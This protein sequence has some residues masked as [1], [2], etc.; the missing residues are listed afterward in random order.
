MEP[1]GI[2]KGAIEIILPKWDPVCTGMIAKEDRVIGKK[3]GLRVLGNAKLGLMDC[4]SRGGGIDC[5][6]LMNRS[7]TLWN[8]LDGLRLNLNPG[9]EY[10]W[11]ERLDVLER[12]YVLAVEDFVREY[13]GDDVHK[14]E[15]KNLEIGMYFDDILIMRPGKQ[16]RINGLD[17]EENSLEGDLMMRN[18]HF[19]RDKK[20]K[21]R[22]TEGRRVLGGGIDG[23]PIP[24]E[25][26]DQ[27][28]I[29][30]LPKRL[31]SVK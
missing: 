11:N 30:E 19:D 29:Y 26:V 16:S 2:D 18:V 15:R 9:P 17:V 23:C 24:Y 22:I 31:S 28:F 27:G 5:L 6:D 13:L 3:R 25:Y 7:A 4:F 20:N 21:F 14:L 12:M 8:Y 10:V 1:T